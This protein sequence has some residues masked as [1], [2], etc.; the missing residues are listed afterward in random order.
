LTGYVKRFHRKGTEFGN[1]S[2]GFLLTLENG[3]ISTLEFRR[4]EAEK[5]KNSRADSFL[6]DEQSLTESHHPLVPEC[7]T[8]V[9][10]CQKTVTESHPEPVI[11]P[12]IEPVTNTILSETSVL[13]VKNRKLKPR[14][15]A[16]IFN[17][18][19]A[20]RRGG[21][22]S[23]LWK[24][25]Q[26][27]KLTPT[28]SIQVINWLVACA[29]SNPEWQVDANGQYVQGITKFIRERIWLTP[30]PVARLSAK[31]SLDMDDVSWAED[32]NEG[33]L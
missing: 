28:D 3:D 23:Q 24:V 5:A 22:D 12:V 4:E 9:S 27:E 21:N 17:L 26:Q 11:E 32:L 13:P 6:L 30:V 1:S 33:L 2:N 25:W 7:P 8:L 19:P 18:Y 29:K 10:E 15:I 20:H 14:F 16:D 31:P